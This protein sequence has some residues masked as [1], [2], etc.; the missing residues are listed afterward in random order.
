L[1]VGHLRDDVAHQPRHV[2]GVLRVALSHE[3]FG[4]NGKVTQPGEA[5]GH[6]GDVLVHAEDFRNHQHHRQVTLAGRR[7]AVGRHL[8]IA[9]GNGHRPGVQSGRVGGDGLRSDRQH[10]RCKAAAHGGLN[11]AAATELARR[12]QAVEVLMV[13]RWAPCKRGGF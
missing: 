9:H 11:K 7:R 5:A 2:G 4:R 10:R 13:H 6:V 3:H 12:R 8:E 1:R